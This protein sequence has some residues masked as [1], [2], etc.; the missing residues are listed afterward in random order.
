MLNMAVPV[1]RNMK[2]EPKILMGLEENVVVFVLM[3]EYIIFMPDDVVNSAM[4]ASELNFH[5]L[6]GR[7]PWGIRVTTHQ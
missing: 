2:L 7:V 3:F 1:A 4:K 6:R 5:L